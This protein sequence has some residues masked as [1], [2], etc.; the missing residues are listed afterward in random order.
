VHFDE[1]GAWNTLLVSP[2]MNSHMRQRAGRMIW[3]STGQEQTGPAI[4][5]YCFGTLA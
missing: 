2:V 5:E 4:T 1:H 3:R